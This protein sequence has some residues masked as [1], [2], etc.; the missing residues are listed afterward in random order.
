M[1]LIMDQNRSKINPKSTQNGPKIDMALFRLMFPVIIRPN[2]CEFRF[3]PRLKVALKRAQWTGRSID[4]PI[5][6]IFR[7]PKPFFV[8]ASS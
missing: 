5:S 3:N 8:R 4:I 6:Q 7:C 2:L 1:E